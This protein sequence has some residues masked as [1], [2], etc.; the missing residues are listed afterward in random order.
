M[1]EYTAKKSE[2]INCNNLEQTS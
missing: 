1:N 2:Y